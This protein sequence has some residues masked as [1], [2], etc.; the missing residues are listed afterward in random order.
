MSSKRERERNRRRRAKKRVW[1]GS[2]VELTVNDVRVAVERLEAWSVPLP[3]DGFYVVDCSRAL[4]ARERLMDRAYKYRGGRKSQ[5][6]QRR[7]EGNSRE[8]LRE[9][10]RAERE[11]ELWADEDIPR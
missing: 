7:V 1:P 2:C 5:S 9:R 11:A 6:A 4:N 10:L 8:R 3:D